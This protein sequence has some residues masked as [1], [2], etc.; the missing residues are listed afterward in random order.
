MYDRLYFSRRQHNHNRDECI[1]L[2]SCIG[3][4]TGLL[5][6][7][8]KC[9]AVYIVQSLLIISDECMTGYMFQEAGLL[10][11]LD[12]CITPTSYIG[13]GTILHRLYCSRIRPTLT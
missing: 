8:D 11:T 9:T 4:G 3:Q 6:I 13:Q 10:I 5:L 7:W 2:T 12:E 1:T